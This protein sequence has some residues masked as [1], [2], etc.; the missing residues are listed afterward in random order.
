MKKPSKK[1]EEAMNFTREKELEREVELLRIEVDYLKKLRTFQ[2]NIMAKRN[3]ES[4][5]E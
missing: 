5:P 2:Q 4:K 1:Q 3:D